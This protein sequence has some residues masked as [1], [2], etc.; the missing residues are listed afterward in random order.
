M[1]KLNS[2]VAKKVEQQESSGGYEPIP[3]GPYTLRLRS[4]DVKEGAKGPYWVWEFE[5]PEGAEEYAGRRFWMNTSLSEAA[6]WKLKEVF[7]AFGE[8][9]DTDTDELC[10]ERVTGYIVQR[11]IQAGERKGELA[12]QIDRVVPFEGD[13]DADDEF[14]EDDDLD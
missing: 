3:P 12:N 2:K 6:L 5:I 8:S 4:V 10:G 13:A 11:T 7:A 9:P 1:P 14:D